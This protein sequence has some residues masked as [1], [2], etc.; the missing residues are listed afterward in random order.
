[1]QLEEKSL[2]S[3]CYYPNIKRIPFISNTF[4]ENINCFFIEI[5]DGNNAKL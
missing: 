1:M 3:W 5:N 2:I 4:S